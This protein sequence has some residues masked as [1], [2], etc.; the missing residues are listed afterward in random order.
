MKKK[1]KRPKKKI[2]RPKKKDGIKSSRLLSRKLPV[3]KKEKGEL[4]K[5]PVVWMATV[6]IEA[7]LQWGSDYKNKVTRYFRFKFNSIVYIGAQRFVDKASKIV[8][9]PYNKWFEMDENTLRN[10]VAMGIAEQENY[11]KIKL[12][13]PKEV[14]KYLSIFTP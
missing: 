10:L 3:R 12:R 2:G 9:P 11:T 6:K 1:F 4:Q 13:A 7:N 14:I 8:M 5:S